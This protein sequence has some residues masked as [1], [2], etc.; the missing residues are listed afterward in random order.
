[1]SLASAISTAQTIFSNTGKQTAVVSQNIANVGN[2]DYSRRMA[3]T[4]VDTGGQPY[5]KVQRAQDDAL[6]KQNISSISASAAQSRLLDGLK[7]IQSAFGGSGYPTSPASYLTSLRSSLQTYSESPGSV[8]IASSAVAEAKDVAKSLNA[9]SDTVDTVK[10]A[11]DAQIGEQVTQLNEYLA[12]FQEA[13]SAVVGA[14]A[15]KKDASEALDKRDS[16]L[17]SIAGIIGISTVTRAGMDTVIYTNDGSVLFEVTPRKIT[18]EAKPGTQF[19]SYVMIDDDQLQPGSGGNTTGQGTLQALFQI[20]DVVAPKMQQQLDEIARGLIQIFQETDQT[21]PTQPGLP[22]LFTSGENTTVPAEGEIVP[23][24]AKLISVNKAVDKN[25]LLLRD[26]G[27]NNE[28]QGNTNYTYNTDNVSSFKGRID[29]FVEG[30]AEPIDFD[31]DADLGGTATIMS[32]ASSSIGWLEQLRKAA[33]DASETKGAMLS[34]TQQAL[35]NATGVSLDEELSLM[36]DLEQSYKASAKL[37]STVDEMLTA[38][39]NMVR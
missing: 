11:A 37:L 20:R 17:K 24:L 7:Q 9:A 13:N 27:I 32:Y 19:P 14:L 3:M 26:G 34:Q 21:D 18:F 16:L 38:L 39:L 1:M 12:S 2:A 8:T 22:G 30:M 6:L 23:N 4:G 31:E 35:S 5:L 25:P 28:A 29:S 15:N 33:T 10:T 36:L